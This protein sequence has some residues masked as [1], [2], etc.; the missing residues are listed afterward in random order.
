M[1][2]RRETRD[3]FA[4]YT[5]VK[6]R[7]VGETEA[8]PSV[9][10][11][12]RKYRFGKKREGD[13]SR[14]VRL[15]AL[16]VVS[17]L[18]VLLIAAI[19]YGFIYERAVEEPLPEA[20]T[21]R[22][23]R[24]AAFGRDVRESVRTAWSGGSDAGAPSASA[25]TNGVSLIEKAFPVVG[26]FLDKRKRVKRAERGEDAEPAADPAA[27]TNAA[28]VVRTREV[29]PDLKRFKGGRRGRRIGNGERK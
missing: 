20:A 19:A 26:S 9:P 28:P 22:I 17:G 27:Q 14:T 6:V 29:D 2:A 1:S 4:G 10:E 24:L 21:N 12:P 15:I 18:L 25:G 23:Q 3:P 13:V 11:R 16:A 5:P 8:P 7:P